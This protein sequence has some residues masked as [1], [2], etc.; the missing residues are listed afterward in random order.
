MGSGQ[1]RARRKGPAVGAGC[2]RQALTKQGWEEGA[3]K[4]LWLGGGREEG[5]SG[6]C[7]GGWRR[8]GQCTGW[9]RHK[10]WNEQTR[11]LF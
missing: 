8:R 9:R 11:F 1:A 6:R 3:G 7:S 4:E 2:C 5:A 10:E